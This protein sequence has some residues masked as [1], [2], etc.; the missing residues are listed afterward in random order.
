MDVFCTILHASC[1]FQLLRLDDAEGK[2]KN[3]E[4]REGE[5]KREEEISNGKSNK[6]GVL[7][8]LYIVLK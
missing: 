3:P 7:F 4:A 5:C 2:K 8:N 6:V 1:R